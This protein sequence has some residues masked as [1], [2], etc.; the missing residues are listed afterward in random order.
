MIDILKEYDDKM[1]LLILMPICFILNLTFSD[2][3]F[4]FVFVWG[5]ANL[6]YLK[7]EK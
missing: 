1:V 7:H 5:G 6:A 2:F 4:W 3:G